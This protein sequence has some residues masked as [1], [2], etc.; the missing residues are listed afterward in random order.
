MRDVGQAADPLRVLLIT[1]GQW[2]ERIASNISANAPANWIVNRWAAPRVIP[3]VVD[4][5]ED[6]LPESLPQ[7]DL[8]V[9]LGDVPGFAQLIPEIAQL[10]DAQAVIAPIDRNASLPKGLA[11][12]LE[13]WLERQGVEVIFPKPFC[14]LTERRINRTPLVQEYDNPIIA[15]FASLFGKPEL[16]IEVE[17][18]V[19]TRVEVQRDAACGCA[20]YVAEHLIGTTVDEAIEQ[21]G[22]LHHHYP[23]LADMNKDEDYRDTLMHVSGNLLKDRVRDSLKTHLAVNYIRPQG[24][25]ED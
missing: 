21:A 3:P 7:S 4:Y 16:D 17:Q 18:G 24:R 12:Q 10:T 22:L 2:G 6:F 1:Q 19:I 8:I 13:G 23:C 20:Q 9:A 25:H 15:E 5:P 14:S 11:R